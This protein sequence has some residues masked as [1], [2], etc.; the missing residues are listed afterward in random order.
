[1]QDQDERKIPTC[2]DKKC[3]FINWPTSKLA[4]SALI[5]NRAGL[6]LMTK[7]GIDPDKGKL[8]L[9]GGF[10]KF[11]ES[12]E[13]GIKREIKEEIGVEIKILD[14]IG[15]GI[16]RYFYQGINDYTLIM[17]MTVKVVKGKIRSAD[18]KEVTAIEWV[19]PNDF[20]ESKLAFKYNAK[21]L[22]K[23]VV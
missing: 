13:A 7:R 6:V 20:D 18:K 19:D 10:L 23:I 16:D 2:D 22:R 11:G 4:T 9:P 5:I 21:F 15:H 14:Y 1:L 3:G 8:D 12:P 17:A